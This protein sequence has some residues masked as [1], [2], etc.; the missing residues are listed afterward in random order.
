MYP[1]LISDTVLPEIHVQYPK[2]AFICTQAT[3]ANNEWKHRNRDSLTLRVDGHPSEAHTLKIPFPQKG[4]GR[5]LVH[6]QFTAAVNAPFQ[7]DSA[8]PPRSST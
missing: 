5:K 1:V 3:S 8:R 2:I 4:T 6:P 7:Q